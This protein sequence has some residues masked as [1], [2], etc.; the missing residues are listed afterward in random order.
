MHKPPIDAMVAIKLHFFEVKKREAELYKK[1]LQ[2]K[3]KSQM[4]EKILKMMQ[5]KRKKTNRR[6]KSAMNADYSNS[7]SANTS[8]NVM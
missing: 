4:G 3:F 7:D 6:T 1:G 2:D 8:F 5:L